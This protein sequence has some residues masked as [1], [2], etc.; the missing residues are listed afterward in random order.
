MSPSLPPPLP[1][2]LPGPRSPRQFD[3]QRASDVPKAANDP[4][5]RVTLLGPGGEDLASEAT[6]VGAFAAGVA[7]WAAPVRSVCR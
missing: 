3:I 4:F 1:P 2:P 6:D 5:V 7:T